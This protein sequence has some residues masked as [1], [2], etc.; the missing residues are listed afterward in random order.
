MFVYPS[1]STIDD[2]FF[3]DDVKTILSLISEKIDQSS[4]KSENNIVFFS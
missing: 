2:E 1:I 4:Y 3:D